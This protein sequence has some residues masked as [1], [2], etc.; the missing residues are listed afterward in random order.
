MK[1]YLTHQHLKADLIKDLLSENKGALLDAEVL[2]IKEFAYQLMAYH[3][4]SAYEIYQG[5]KNLKLNELNECIKD[6][7]F[8][9]E[10]YENRS[11]LAAYDI[12]IDDLKIHDEYKTLLKHTLHFDFVSFYQKFKDIKKE[13][14][15]LRMIKPDLLETKIIDLLGVPL[16]KTFKKG[17]SYKVH[18]QSSSDSLD[19]IAQYI[20]KEDLDINKCA[21][22]ASENNLANAKIHL[23]LYG[24]PV[25]VT[26]ND[27]NL[28]AL[29]FISIIDYYLHP[30]I[31]NYYEMVKLQV[32]DALADH[33]FYEY[34]SRH[35]E[36]HLKP[37]ERFDKADGYYY[38][39]ELKAQKIHAKYLPFLLK[40]SAVTDLKEAFMIA[41]E[42]IARN[43]QDTKSLKRTIEKYQ[44]TDLLEA[45]PFIKNELL[46][47]RSH[48]VSSEGIRLLPFNKPLENYEYLFI[49]DPDTS[50]YPKLKEYNGFLN[51]EELVKKGF[52]TLKERY[53]EAVSLFESYLA[54]EKLIYCLSD[55]SFDNHHL[56]YDERFAKIADLN[57]ELDDYAK[58]LKINYDL[59]IKNTDLF[60]DGKVL[61]GSISSFENY[62]KCHY[63]YFLKYG[64]GLKDP[65]KMDLD[66]AL[67]GVISHKVMERLI[68]N[69]ADK[70]N[71]AKDYQK[72]LSDVLNDY[73]KMLTKIYP[74][75]QPLIQ[76]LLKRISENI[77]NEMIFIAKMEKD[78]DFI[79]Y[80]F[81]YYFDLDFLKHE[82]LT[83]HLKGII[84][85]VDL[86]DDHFRIIDYKTSKHT[87]NKE[88][89]Y[90]GLKLQ[91]LTYLLIYEKISDLKPCGAF[92]LNITH[93]KSK[94]DDY[95]F[96]YKEGLKEKNVSDDDKYEDFINAHRLNGLVAEDLSG[97]DKNY[98]CVATRK[99][100]AISKDRLINIEATKEALKDIYTSLLQSLKDG[101]ISL[102]PS[103]DACDYCRFHSIC[104][105]KGIKGLNK[106]KLTACD[107]GEN[108]E[109]Q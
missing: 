29:Q 5:L 13:D 49:L 81:E 12:V 107:I 103:E 37:F 48:A 57:Y 88:E 8:L 96:S 4:P 60:F 99:K 32:E 22:I 78:S 100:N 104:H 65:N 55:Y 9:N 27:H 72:T 58:E 11:I 38:D 94:Y 91:L 59:K 50:I 56:E 30:D 70:K 10:L 98:E 75:E 44:G 33:D 97:L 15:E 43:D 62:F 92:Y 26:S 20:I 61:K 105:F 41:F 1:I 46:T 79:P 40:L 71:Y 68:K 85:R 51:D 87:L 53:D 93:P 14:I 82:D 84:D 74:K 18:N 25:N 86:L 76:A 16:N 67:V 36:D 95:A 7:V 42:K 28:K 102:N 6:T 80:L 89:F 101:D 109:V 63:A 83:L 31:D 108:D 64:L 73:Q 21:I 52:P 90:R 106:T 34:L 54:N 66:A 17:L 77:A 2:S 3:R 69:S 24:L 19:F 45:Y 35:C 39:L 47:L 23:S